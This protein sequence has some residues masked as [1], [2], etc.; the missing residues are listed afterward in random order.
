MNTTAVTASINPGW[1]WQNTYV[2]LPEPLFSPENPTPV[3]NPKAVLVNHQLAAALGLQ[4]YI[5]NIDTVSLQLGGNEIPEGAFPIAQAYMGHQFG[6]LNMLGD[7]RAILLGEHVTSAGE[8]FD[9]HLKGS[10]PTRYSRRG[11]G[12]ATLSAC[13]REYIISEAMFQLGIPTSRSL[14]VVSTGE[15]VY[16]ER[17]Q[18]GGVLTRVMESHI[19]VGTFEYAVR[20]LERND[21][22]QFINYVADRHYPSLKDAANLPLA[23]LREV[24]DRQIDLVI[25]WIRVGFIHGVMNT[26]NMSIAGQT[27]DY[28]PCAFMN[29]YNPATVFSSVDTGGRYAFAHQP[30]IAQWNLAVLAG[31]LIPLID[32]VE[33]NAVEKAKAVIQTFPDIYAIRFRNMMKQ[34]LGLVHDYPE[35]SLLMNDL[36][37]WM[38]MTGA[39]YTNTFRHLTWN[40]IPSDDLYGQDGFKIWLCRYR[41]RLDKNGIAE[42]QSKAL[43]KKS[44]PCYIPRNHLVEEALE[45]ATLGYDYT[46]LLKLMEV[47]EKPYALREL[48]EKYTLP[49]SGGEEHYR[50]FCNT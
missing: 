19:R 46:H 16:R 26:D 36:L 28:G 14:A 2:C 15:L 25:H 48:S 10:G 18:D 3:K 35:D 1:H 11:D 49:P 17:V 9:I 24:M 42:E 20:H 5:D 12:R 43:M 32:E 8:R 34:K 4:M 23:L 13:L 50:T 21:F 39:D 27:F 6:Y 29:R 33:E 41:E 30:S 22:E 44:N 40:T 37:Q 38:Q 45:A 7:G 31:T 47:L